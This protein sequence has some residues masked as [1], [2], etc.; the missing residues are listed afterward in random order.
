MST[1][2]VARSERSAP[3][4]SII[5]RFK[6]NVNNPKGLKNLK[7][8][9]YLNVFFGLARGLLWAENVGAQ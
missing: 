6:K 9:S 5:A 8:D 1:Q 3:R 7:K 2:W 4:T